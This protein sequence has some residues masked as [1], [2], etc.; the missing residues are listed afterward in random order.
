MAT[1]INVNTD[2]MAT[3]MLFSSVDTSGWVFKAPIE[4][5]NRKGSMMLFVDKSATDRA[6]PRFQ[7]CPLDSKMTAP[8][9]WELE[10]GTTLE[11]AIAKPG[12]KLKLQLNT[13]GDALTAFITKLDETLVAQAKTNRA[14]WWP[15]KNMTES[16]IEKDA[17]PLLKKDDM[18]KYPDKVKIKVL[19]SGNRK[20]SIF[21]CVRDDEDFLYTPAGPECVQAGCQVVPVV[22]CGGV[23]ISGLGYGMDLIATTLMVFNNHGKKRSFDMIINKPVREA[24][25]EEIANLNDDNVADET[26]SDSDQMHA[27]VSSTTREVDLEGLQPMGE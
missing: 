3:N 1:T 20:T 18:G 17:K 12:G 14:L 27:L 22:E 25:T 4:M 2:N 16:K 21:R 24:T 10:D 23:W 9:G 8:F 15:G 26:A 6:A 13:T 19:T 7:L 11:D 5:R